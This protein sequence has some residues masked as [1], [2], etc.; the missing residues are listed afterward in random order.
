MKGKYVHISIPKLGA[1]G[2]VQP[3]DKLAEAL[4]GEFDGAAPG[5]TILLQLVEMTEAEYKKLPE[6][7]GW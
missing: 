5:D 7:E 3:I 6:F 1:R 2:Y 4:V